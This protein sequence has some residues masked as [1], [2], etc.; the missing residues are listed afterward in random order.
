LTAEHGH[1]L[2]SLIEDIREQRAREFLSDLRIDVNSIALLLG[3]SD[4]RAFRRAFLRWTGQTPSD[5]RNTMR[6]MRE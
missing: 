4:D 5:F 3:Y 1:T 2:Q 6:T